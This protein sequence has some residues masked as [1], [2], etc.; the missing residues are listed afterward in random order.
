MVCYQRLS[1][2]STLSFIPLGGSRHGSIPDLESHSGGFR[3]RSIVLISIFQGNGI[4]IS[5]ACKLT[6]NI[7]SYFRGRYDTIRFSRSP[8]I[9]YS[10]RYDFHIR[11]EIVADE[12]LAQ[13]PFPRMGP[14][15]PFTYRMVSRT[16]TTYF[17]CVPWMTVFFACCL[18][19][20]PKRPP[21]VLC[22]L[23][24]LR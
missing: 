19:I 15:I 1:Y 14:S 24:S 8:Y 7:A 20:R 12:L 6:P 23:L 2:K 4:G 9:D 16:N 13:K 11:C 10:S 21:H 3:S 18:S 22:V 5:S 17:D